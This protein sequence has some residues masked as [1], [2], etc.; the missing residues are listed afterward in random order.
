[1]LELL[2]RFFL[3]LLDA[4]GLTA[5]VWLRVRREVQHD[6]TSVLNVKQLSWDAAVWCE[7][8]EVFSRQATRE[9]KRLQAEATARRVVVVFDIVALV[10]LLIASCYCLVHDTREP[11]AYLMGCSTC[12]SAVLYGQLRWLGVT[13]IWR[14]EL[15]DWRA[16]MEKK[17]A[18][19]RD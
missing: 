15:E 13:K 12:F 10:V 4:F 1:M 8:A 6:L 19:Y 2:V 5:A 11:I 16:S 9:L 3:P 14:E 7:T 18:D 17:L